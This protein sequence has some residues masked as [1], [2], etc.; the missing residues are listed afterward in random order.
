MNCNRVTNLMSAYVDGELTGAE[1]LAIR[2]HIHGCEECSDEYES[3]R[4][5]KQA[6]AGLRNVAPRKDF[7]QA[8]LA[9][10][11]EVQVPPHQRVLNKLARFLHGRLSPVAAALVASGFAIVMLT[12]GGIDGVSTEYAAPP[13][14]AS[15]GTHS[16]AFIRESNQPVFPVD[17]NHPVTVVSDSQL[18][19]G[20]MQL[21][22]FGR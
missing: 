9:R 20:Q 6:V 12:A 5:M 4:V 1:M 15:T 16:V 11:E 7:A 14:I 19:G 2:R 21:A 3:T 18:T 10:I 17:G 13:M 8:I 22:S